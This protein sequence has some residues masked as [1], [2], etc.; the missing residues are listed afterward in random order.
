VTIRVDR[1][2]L[3]VVN[4]PQR[5]RTEHRPPARPSARTSR[6]LGLE[7]FDLLP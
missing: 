1:F 6:T 3:Q 2:S 7:H 5:P 4:R